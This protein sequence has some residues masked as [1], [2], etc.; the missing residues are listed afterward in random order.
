MSGQR[1]ALARVLADQLSLFRLPPTDP[2]TAVVVDDL[3]DLTA[4]AEAILAH[5]NRDGTPEC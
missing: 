2:L 1:D 4:V 3:V 5:F